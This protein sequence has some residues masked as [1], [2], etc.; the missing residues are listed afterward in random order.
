MDN[1]FIAFLIFWLVV[2]AVGG[3]SVFLLWMKRGHRNPDFVWESWTLLFPVGVAA[4]LIVWGVNLEPDLLADALIQIA[5][6]IVAGVIV[7]VVVVVLQ[8]RN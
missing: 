4:G 8:D 1:A 6:A 7:G 3:L 5:T 2:I